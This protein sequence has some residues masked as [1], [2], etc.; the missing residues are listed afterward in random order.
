MK[1]VIN[2]R[3]GGFGL[4]SKAIEWLYRNGSKFVKPVLEDVYFGTSKI[5]EEEKQRH[6]ELCEI[7]RLEIQ[8]GKHVL[9]N[10]YSSDWSS[11]TDPMLIKCVESLKEESFGHSAFL[12]IIDIPDVVDF[13][14]EEYDG[15]EWVAEKHKTWS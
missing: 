14:I 10:E 2:S 12:K 1:I 5:L 6:A 7:P 13:V 4:S 3:Y 9:I 11:R 8:G 15:N